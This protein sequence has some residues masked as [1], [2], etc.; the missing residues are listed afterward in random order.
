[1]RQL[2]SGRWLLVSLA[3]FNG[4]RTTTPP[5]IDICIGDG[6]GGSDCVLKTGARVYRLPSEMRNYWCTTQADMAA[7]S[8]WAYDADVVVIEAEMQKTKQEV[9]TQP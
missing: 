1:M 5:K 7:F 6:L 8:S 3:L 9:L 2:L 4:C